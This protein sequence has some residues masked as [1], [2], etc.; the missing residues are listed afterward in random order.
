VSQSQTAPGLDE[1][2]IAGGKGECHPRRHEGPPPARSEHGV[3]TGMEIGP[4][5][6]WARV[7]RHGQVGIEEDEGHLEHRMTL[8]PGRAP[9]PD[10]ASERSSARR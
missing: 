4:G 8:P 3:L 7:R 2:G 9:R 5:V 10:P 1:T 6:A